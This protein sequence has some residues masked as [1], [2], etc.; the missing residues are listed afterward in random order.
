M[1]ACVALVAAPSFFV[2]RLAML[3]PLPVQPRKKRDT[4][5]CTEVK[6]QRKPTPSE[7]QPRDFEDK[8]LGGTQQVCFRRQPLA[9]V[10]AQL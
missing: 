10:G 3:P 9:A 4:N 1:P 5:D 7:M 8:V 6:M 2:A